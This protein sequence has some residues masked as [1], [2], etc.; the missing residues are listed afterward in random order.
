MSQFSRASHFIH[1]LTYPLPL[2]TLKKDGAGRS[3]KR[4]GTVEPLAEGSTWRHIS[5][6]HQLDP[7]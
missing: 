6:M 5:H 7:R 3:S 4:P 2:V 1:H